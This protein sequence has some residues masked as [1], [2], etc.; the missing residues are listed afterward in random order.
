LKGTRRA[1][2]RRA[3]DAALA[4]MPS[5]RRRVTVDVDPLSVL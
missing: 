4:D 3:L 1:D 2:M 5:V